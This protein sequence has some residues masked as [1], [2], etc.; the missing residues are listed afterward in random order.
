[1]IRIG[2]IM[3]LRIEC[4]CGDCKTEEYPDPCWIYWEYEDGAITLR[5]EAR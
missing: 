5:V 2:D 3:K 1:M 4:D